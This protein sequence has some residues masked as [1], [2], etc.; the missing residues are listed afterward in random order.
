MT[1]GRLGKDKGAKKKRSAEEERKFAE[2]IGTKPIVGSGAID[3]IKG[4]IPDKDF[5]IEHKY[6]DAKSRSVKT[7]ELNKITKEARDMNK[8]PMFV[9]KFNNGMCVGVDDEWCLVPV[10]A[11]REL[12]LLDNE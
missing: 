5:L 7:S 2:K 11:L 3:G 9:I 1:F 6:T 8:Y 10:H 4:D 12:G